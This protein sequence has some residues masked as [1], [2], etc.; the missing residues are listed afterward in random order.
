MPIREDRTHGRADV[1]VE[2]QNLLCVKA[3]M[4]APSPISL[5]SFAFPTVIMF[6]NRFPG[7]A[8][9]R[10]F[11]KQVVVV[12]EEHPIYLAERTVNAMGYFLIRKY[13]FPQAKNEWDAQDIMREVEEQ[14]VSKDYFVSQWAK[15]GDKDEQK[16]GWK[17]VIKNQLF[18]KRK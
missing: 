8:L 4:H 18:G 3:K 1:I 9:T 6:S 5:T 2:L 13:Y 12:P 7:A 14:G 15:E 11:L 17:G 16:S 10:K